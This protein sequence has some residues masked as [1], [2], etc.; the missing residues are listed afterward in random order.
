MSKQ[1]KELSA[2]LYKKTRL[3]CKR[4]LYIKLAKRATN[5]KIQAKLAT[6]VHL[7]AVQ[8]GIILNSQ[9]QKKRDQADALIDVFLWLMLAQRC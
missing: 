9:C 8:V 2:M 7:K 1:S 4:N 6:D 5:R 3:I